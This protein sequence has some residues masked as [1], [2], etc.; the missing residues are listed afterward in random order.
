MTHGRTKKECEDVLD[1][2]A[3]E[4]GL[5]ERVVLYSTKEWKKT[6]LVYF[7]PDAE[8]WERVHAPVADRVARSHAAGARG[9][10]LI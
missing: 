6:R 7:S 3:A 1:A 2:I 4:T 8:E 5:G 9:V 10:L